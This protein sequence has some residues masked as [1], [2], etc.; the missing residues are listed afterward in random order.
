MW[1]SAY[2]ELARKD[3]SIKKLPILSMSDSL[4]CRLVGIGSLFLF[5][6]AKCHL[7]IELTDMEQHRN[8]GSIRR[9]KKQ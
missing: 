6:V 1:C 3:L 5:S 8:D 7:Q 9:I 2:E 4:Y